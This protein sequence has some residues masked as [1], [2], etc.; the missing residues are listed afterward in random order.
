MIPAIRLNVSPVTTSQAPH[1]RA[2]AR[3]ASVR[4]VR[5]VHHSSAPSAISAAGS[6]QAI[7]PP[8]SEPKS[9]VSPV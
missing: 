7:C 3:S 4:G 2:A 8:N 6:S 9:R 5:R 1:A